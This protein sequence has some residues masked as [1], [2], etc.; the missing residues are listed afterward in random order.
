M[1]VDL[2]SRKL[3]LDVRLTRLLR[4]RQAPTPSPLAILAVSVNTRRA[5]G[6]TKSRCPS[7]STS[8]VFLPLS[9]SLLPFLILP[10]DL[11]LTMPT[12]T[13]PPVHHLARIPHL[14]FREIRPPP[15][16]A[17]RLPN[18]LPLPLHSLSSSRSSLLLRRSTLP[19]PRA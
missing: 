18:P 4:S 1:T 14:R 6:S 3:T 12:E 11:A 10:T 5:A 7:S 13:P 15:D 2:P 8:Y 19:R 9:L 17:H 16:P